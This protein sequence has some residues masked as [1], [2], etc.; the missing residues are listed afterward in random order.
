MNQNMSSIKEKI[1]KKKMKEKNKRKMNTITKAD[2]DHLY[3][4]RIQ[5]HICENK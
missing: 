4:F 2:F 1:T 3:Y 5:Q